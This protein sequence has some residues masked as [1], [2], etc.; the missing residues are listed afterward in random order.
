MTKF[1]ILL[2][3]AGALLQNNV[4]EDNSGRRR[5]TQLTQFSVNS[6]VCAVSISVKGDDLDASSRAGRMRQCEAFG[7]YRPCRD[8]DAVFVTECWGLLQGLTCGSL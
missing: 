1:C 4:S 8:A 3:G 6:V 5:V 7:L 2:F